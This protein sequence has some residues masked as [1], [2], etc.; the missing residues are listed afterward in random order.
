MPYPEPRDQLVPGRLGGDGNRESLD[1]DRAINGVGRGV[2][3]VHGA[4]L[5]QGEEHRVD[6]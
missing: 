4:V 2:N 5:R 6:G 1:C 3:H